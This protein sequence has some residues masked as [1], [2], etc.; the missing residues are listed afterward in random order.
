MTNSPTPRA[1]RE[2][3]RIDR[4]ADI[5]VVT[6]ER[7]GEDFYLEPTW[8]AVWDLSD[9]SHDV[10]SIAKAIDRDAWAALDALADLGLLEARVAPPVGSS[11]VTRRGLLKASAV[12]GAIAATIAVTARP[13]A[14]SKATSE[15]RLKADQQKAEEH[16]KKKS[17]E[18][19][20]KEAK[21]K[22]RG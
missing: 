14:A 9:G 20:N 18:Q 19:Q 22:A 15:E 8:L 2:G 13:A 16:D 12:A 4:S 3:I 11:V 21:L 10:A 7:T 5:A 1:R 17:G 6:D